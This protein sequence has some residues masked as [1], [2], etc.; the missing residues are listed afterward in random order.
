LHV[1]P[2]TQTV[3]PEYVFPPHWPH[4]GT[5][6]PVGVGVAVEETFVVVLVC[7]VLVALVVVVGYTGALQPEGATLEVEDTVDA[8]LVT[9]VAV[10]AAARTLATL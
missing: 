7:N 8:E 4:C 6:T 9:G 5:V 2:A 10:A 1:Q 3:D